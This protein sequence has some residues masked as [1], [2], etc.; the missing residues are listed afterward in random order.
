MSSMSASQK[1]FEEFD[2]GDLRESNF[3]MG[4]A[5]VP[6]HKGNKMNHKIFLR[7]NLRMK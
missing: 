7:D 5:H 6:R 3:Y 2:E 1:S 4:G